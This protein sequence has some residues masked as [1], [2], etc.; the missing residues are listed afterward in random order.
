MLFRSDSLLNN[1]FVSANCQLIKTHK[2]D[3]LYNSEYRSQKIDSIDYKINKEG[4]YLVGLSTSK[5]T[6]EEYKWLYVSDV[7][8]ITSNFSYKN[9]R[10]IDFFSVDALSGHPISNIKIELMDRRKDKYIS[11]IE[12]NEVGRASYNLNDLKDDLYISEIK[13][14]RGQQYLFSENI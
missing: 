12:T 14:Y 6:Q 9:N 7:K 11:S 2:L 8:I 4:I 13:V 10:S 3:N 1:Q 5:N